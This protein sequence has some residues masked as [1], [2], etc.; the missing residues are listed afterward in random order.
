MVTTQLKTGY[1]EG[2]QVSAAEVL[3]AKFEYTKEQTSLKLDNERW[4]NRRRMSWIALW[5]IMIVTIC[6]LF[7]VPETRLADLEETVTWF[8]FSMASIISVYIGSAT[9]SDIKAM[10]QRRS[11]RNQ[12]P[13]SEYDVYQ[14]AGAIADNPDQENRNT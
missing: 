3:K 4:K 2:E 1:S 8:Y 10:A 7:F 13:Y 6:Q 14:Q 9:F 12:N 11:S 5:A